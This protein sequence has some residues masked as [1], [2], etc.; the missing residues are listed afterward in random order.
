M[1]S[2]LLLY[3]I[4]NL[5][6]L[7]EHEGSGAKMEKCQTEKGNLLSLYW[8]RSMVCLFFFL[9][10]LSF[11]SKRCVLFFVLFFSCFTLFL[12]SFLTTDTLIS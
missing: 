5:F 8:D 7:F 4:D 9:G 11:S 2:P 3:D 10:F 1:W 6:S 12:F